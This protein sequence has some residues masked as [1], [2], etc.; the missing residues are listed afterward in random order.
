MDG[1]VSI[2]SNIGE[3]QFDNGDLTVAIN[4]MGGSVQLSDVDTQGSNL[5]IDSKSN[6]TLANIELNDSGA[7]SVA[8]DTDN[9]EAAFLQ[10]DGEIRNATSVTFAAGG[11]TGTDDRINVAGN[12]D[13]D[14]GDIDFGRCQRR[15]H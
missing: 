10:L 6:V 15:L 8:F 13:A 14:A 2:L 11:G 1:N 3:I 5:T 4:S 7:I 9:N 12:I